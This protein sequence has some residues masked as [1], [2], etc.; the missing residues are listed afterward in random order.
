MPEV[1]NKDGKMVPSYE[2]ELHSHLT[3]SASQC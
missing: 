2:G 1:K 3:D